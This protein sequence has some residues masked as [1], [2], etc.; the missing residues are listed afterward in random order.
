MASL[1]ERAANN[2]EWPALLEHLAGLCAGPLAAE[3]MRALEPAATL[4]EA[5]ERHRR[6]EAALAA[7]DLADP[8]VGDAV[9]AIDD[10][11]EHV[12][13]GGVASGEELVDVGRVLDAARTLRAYAKRREADVPLLAELLAS[14]PTL[15]P[16][17][18]DLRRCL[19]GSGQVVD[20][21]SSTL[22]R[23]RREVHRRRGDLLDTIGKLASKHADVLREGSYVERDGRYGLPVR[24]DAHRRVEGI[25]L[26][27]SATGATV[28]VEP[29]TV[30]RLNNELRIAEGD[31]EREIARVLASLSDGVRSQCEAI[32]AAHA[33]LLEADHLA[34]LSR[35]AEQTRAR[36]LPLEEEAAIDLVR[37]R[38]PL[39]LAQGIEVVATDLTLRAGQAMVISGPNAGGKT[40]ALKCLGLAAWMARAGIPIPCSEGSRIGWF[41][42]VL[43]DI[44]DNQSLAQSLSTFSA[45]V[46]NLSRMLAEAD[47]QSLVLLDEVAGGTDPEEGSALAAGVLEA[48]LERGAA[49]AATTHYERLKDLAAEDPRF[50]NASVGFDFES[51]APTFTLTLGVPGASSALAVAS[52]FGMPASVVARARSLM[53]VE[54][55]DREKLLADLHREQ[56]LAREARAQAET[57]AAEVARL[58]AEL[59]EE[60]QNVR[61]RERQKLRRESEGLMAEVRRARQQLRALDDHVKEGGRRGAERAIDEAARVVAVGGELDEATREPRHDDPVPAD[62]AVGDVVYL[63]RLGTAGT[64]VE[65][66]ARGEAKVRAGAFVLRVPLTELAKGPPRKGPPPKPPKPKKRRNPS[67]DAMEAPERAPMRTSE[68]TCDL[69]GMRVEEALEEVDRFVD[70]FLTGGVDD[71]GY[72][73]H[74]HGT[75]ALKK[76]V[77]DHLALHGHIASQRAATQQEGGDA[78]TVFW[79]RT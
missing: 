3:R 40:V 44:G 5:Q 58:R 78:F 32:R 41:S 18:H 75:G 35:F 51:M 69:R 49:V 16:L 72:V 71:V 11:L 59:T 22:K 60:R 65:A 26:G 76:A 55:R 9:P 2:L 61:E 13:K 73:L 21:A 62:L 56:R 70:R 36:V 42:A 6:G 24:A 52:R 1:V 39:L 27:S 48:L 30:T 25:V 8:I 15:D 67:A 17:L 7:L 63:E 20:E 12:D 53:S 38:H 23:A 14:D 74:G 34:A 68:N 31:V 64:I 50:V 47:E 29:P 77:R 19:D 10:V 66:P 79:V 43:T 37:M 28:Y 4:A 54:A 45:Q 33:A 46:N 57:D